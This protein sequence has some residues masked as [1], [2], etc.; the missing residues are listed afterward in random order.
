MLN[1]LPVDEIRIVRSPHPRQ[2]RDRDVRSVEDD[3]LVDLVADHDEVVPLAQRR[4][5]LELV[6]VEDATRRVVRGVEQQAPGCGP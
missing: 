6:P 2:R 5:L 3:V 4:D 1:V